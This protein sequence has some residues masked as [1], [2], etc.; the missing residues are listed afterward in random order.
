[1]GLTREGEEM[2]EPFA[3]LEQCLMNEIRFLKRAVA[4]AADEAV[5]MGQGGTM[6]IVRFGEA[7]DGIGF[8][9][10]RGRRRRGAGLGAR[11]VVLEGTDESHPL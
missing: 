8:G 5:G 7:L 11:A 2:I 10:S 9:P 3:E 6:S 1:M 4:R